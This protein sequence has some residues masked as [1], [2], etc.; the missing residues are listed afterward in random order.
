MPTDALVRTIVNLLAFQL[1]LIVIASVGLWFA[2][3]SRK[4]FTRVST[5]AGWG[6]GLLIAYSLASVTLSALTL[7]LRIDARAG[8]SPQA[9]GE[10]LLWLNLLGLSVYPL[11]VIGIAL[12]AR[13][14]FLERE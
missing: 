14:V 4:Y 3:S 13:A 9:V 5:W 2:A 11:F 12:I 7:Q 10:S 6:F 1:P 8:S